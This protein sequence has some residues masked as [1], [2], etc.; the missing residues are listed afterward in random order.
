MGRALLLP[1]LAASALL[2]IGALLLWSLSRGWFYPDLLP[3]HFGLESWR[4]LLSGTN[5]DRLI[6]STLRSLLLAVGTGAASALLALPIGRA[7]SHLRGWRRDLG[8]AAAFLP[9]AAPPLALAIGLQFSFL[10]VG[11]GASYTGVLLAHLI[12]ATGYT[13]L[14]FVGVLS[15][16]DFRVEEEARLLGASAGRTIRSVTLPL[17]RSALGQAFILGFLVSWAQ[18]PLTLLIGQGV[19]PTLPLEVFAYLEAGQDALAA[20]GALLLIL[21]PVVVIG[22]TQWAFREAAVVAV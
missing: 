19:V 15:A 8:L 6:G 21:P 10:S 20:T 5:R 18:V 16:Y 11:L 22:I 13:T 2:P 4:S 14:F 7:L 3:E 9:V 1:V 12:P 17:L